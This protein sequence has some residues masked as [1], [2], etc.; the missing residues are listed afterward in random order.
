MHAF[1]IAQQL[2]TAAATV[3]TDKL[4]AMQSNMSQKMKFSASSWPDI[5]DMALLRLLGQIFST[6]DL[7]HPIATPAMLFMCQALSQCPIQNEIDLGRG[8]FLTLIAYEVSSI[9]L[10]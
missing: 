10:T 2:P 7:T 6:S 4:K 8:L 1:D 9:L 5:E 3:F